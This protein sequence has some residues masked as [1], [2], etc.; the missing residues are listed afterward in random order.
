MN[1][2]FQTSREWHDHYQGVKSRIHLAG[3][4]FEQQRLEEK[5]RSEL[6]AQERLVCQLHPQIAHILHYAE[7]VLPWSSLVKHVCKRYGFTHTQLIGDARPARLVEAR[8]E[9]WWLVRTISGMSYPKMAQLARRDHSSII[10]GVAK[11]GNKLAAGEVSIDR[12]MALR[13]FGEC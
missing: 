7:T 11:F 5:R 13:V 8:H 4:R 12:E 10:H 9:L 6:E 3:A 1:L 2:S